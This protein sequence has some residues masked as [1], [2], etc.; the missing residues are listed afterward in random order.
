MI[1]PQTIVHP[2]GDEMYMAVV[3]SIRSRM[4]RPFCLRVI[5]DTHAHTRIRQR[6]ARPLHGK[7][8]EDDPYGGSTDEEN[9]M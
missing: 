5:I 9:G 4:G 7:D 2:D 1:F 6:Q 3:G 8:P